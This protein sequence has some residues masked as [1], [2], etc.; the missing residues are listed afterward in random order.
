ME[1]KCIHLSQNIENVS[2]EI[3]CSMKTVCHIMSYNM[4]DCLSACVTCVLC[5]LSDICKS[6]PNVSAQ[7]RNCSDSEAKKSST[8]VKEE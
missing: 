7:P 2:V 1:Y 5:V 4:V 6:L 8:E 3:S